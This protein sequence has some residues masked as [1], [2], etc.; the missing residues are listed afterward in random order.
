MD[1]NWEVLDLLKTAGRQAAGYLAQMQAT[2]ALLEAR[3]FEAFNRMSAFVVHDLK[4]IVTQLSLMLK[5]AERL[6]DNPEFQQDML[7][8][9]ES[10]LEKMRQ[11][12]LQLREGATPPAAAA[13][14]NWSPSCAGWIA[15]GLGR[16]GPCKLESQTS[17]RWPPRPRR[18]AGACVGHLV[19]NALDA[20]PP[21]AVSGLR[22]SGPAGR[23]GRGRRHR[24]GMSRGV[25]A[26][27]CFGPS[28]PPRQRHGHRHLREFSVHPRTRRQR[29]LRGQPPG[30]RHRVTVLLPLFEAQRGQICCARSGM[31]KATPLL[32]VEDDLALQKQIK[33]SLDRFESVTASDRESAGAGAPAPARRGHDGPG[34]AA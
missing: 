6:H 26:D 10:S 23:S 15:N 12:M 29:H 2:E 9:V 5:N 24:P 3:K 17:N 7:L 34:P 13:G 30:P 27:R 19:Q 1:L 33:W 18:A 32:I 16:A 21:M 25:R 28:T 20:T 4:N 31:S 8:T 11:L 14:W 22:C